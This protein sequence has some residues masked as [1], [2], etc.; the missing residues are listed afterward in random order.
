MAF[1]I[2]Q[3]CCNDAT[4]VAVCPVNCIHPTPD[5]PDFGTTEM[6]YVDPRT[7]IDCG[8]CADA[9]P[10]DA[11]YEAKD[12]PDPLRI[13]ADLNAGYY[14][15]KEQARTDPAPNFHTWAPTVFT[16]IIPSDLPAL[17]VA[18]VGTGPAGMYAVEDLLL[19]T[20]AR[21]TLIDRLPVAGGLVRYGVAPDHGAT[22]RIGESFARFHT[23]PRVRMRLG[24]EVGRDVTV[25]ELAARYD[26]VIYA[27]GAS[28]ARRLGIPGEDLPGSLAA[29]TVVSWYNGH[30]DVAPNAVD[31]SA[32]RVVV[33]GTGNVALDIARILTADPNTLDGTSISREALLCL[34][35]SKVREVVL[36]GRRGPDDAAYTTPEL[37]GLTRRTDVDLVLDAHDPGVLAAVDSSTGKAALLRDIRRESI[38][39]SASPP[40]GPKRIVFRFASAPAEIL[41]DA[42]VSGL[43]VTRNVGEVAMKADRVVRAVGFRGKPV[44]GLPFDDKSGT[45]PNSRG[46]VDGMPGTYVVGWIKRGSSG[47]I[48]ANRTCAEDTVGA[49]IEDAAAGLIGRAAP[50]R[51][52]VLSSLFG[53]R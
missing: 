22:K 38:D 47:G 35:S 30:P 42:Q 25:A 1:A 50:A 37:L 52:S 5:E 14:E 6:L 31:L 36:L 27:V 15:D 18:V 28:E 12:L 8:A 21:V 41:G 44:P 7:C 43:W 17:D 39:W 48:G 46:R 53:S 13:Y 2:T 49:L 51:R 20:S 24:V 26:A 11:I 23:H 4:C 10:V 3:T 19:H 45:V 34:R 29:T 32:E 33:I 16:R 40:D 9:C